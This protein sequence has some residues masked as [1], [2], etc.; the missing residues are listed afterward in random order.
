[1]PLPDAG[2]CVVHCPAAPAAVL[3]PPDMVFADRRF[4]FLLTT[5]GHLAEDEA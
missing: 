5:G 2:P 1:M 3:N 4:A